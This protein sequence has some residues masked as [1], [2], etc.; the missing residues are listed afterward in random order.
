VV[1]SG[2]DTPLQPHKTTTMPYYSGTIHIEVSVMIN[3]DASPLECSIP[4]NCET[5][6]TRSN[7][8][9]ED[10]SFEIVLLD[11]SYV[12][13]EWVSSSILDHAEQCATD[14]WEKD[15]EKYY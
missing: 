7:D 2:S 15:F 4:F 10:D 5:R 3:E 12:V 1:V 6:T 8:P 14:Q 9:T 13:P 11:P